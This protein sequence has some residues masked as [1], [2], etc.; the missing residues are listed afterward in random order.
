[1]VKG[2]ANKEETVEVYAASLLAITADHPA[3]RA[4]LD[5]LAARLGLEPELA[6]TI[7]RTIEGATV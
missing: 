6:R 5:M 2:A 3:E 1:V 4:Y 7:E